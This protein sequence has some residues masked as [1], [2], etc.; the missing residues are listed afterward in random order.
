MTDYSKIGKFVLGAV[1]IVATPLCIINSA[2]A[3]LAFFWVMIALGAY[4][5]RYD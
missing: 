4:A 1:A 2:W 3:T 5:L